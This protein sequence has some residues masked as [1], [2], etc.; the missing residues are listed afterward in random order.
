MTNKIKVTE[1]NERLKLNKDDRKKI[2]KSFLLGLGGFVGAFLIQ[3]LPSIDYGAYNNIVY[4][5][6]PFVVNFIRKLI[7][8]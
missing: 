2:I 6:M 7:K 1:K 4:T 3:T 5:M 8:K